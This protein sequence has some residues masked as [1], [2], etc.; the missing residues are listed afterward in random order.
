MPGISGSDSYHAN[1]NF[2]SASD[3]EPSSDAQPPAQPKPKPKPLR[4]TPLREMEP[5]DRAKYLGDVAEEY[6]NVHSPV[7]PDSSV[8]EQYASVDTLPKPEFGEDRASFGKSVEVPCDKNKKDED[9]RV[10]AYQT[11]RKHMVESGPKARKVLANMETRPDAETRPDVKVQVY[12][13]TGKNRIP[14]LGGGEPLTP[15]TETAFSEDKL[16]LKFD[17]HSAVFNQNGERQSAATS[18]GHEAKHTTQFI[19]RIKGINGNLS[20]G[21]GFF[22]PGERKMQDP[23]TSNAEHEDFTGVEAEMAEAHEDQGEAP[24]DAHR[25]V[26]TYRTSGMTS[27]TPEN[28]ET[29]KVL[30]KFQPQLRDLTKQMDQQG[31]L[32]HEY[33]GQNISQPALWRR[34]KAFEAEA[35]LKKAEASSNVSP[36]NA[37]ISVNQLVS[38]QA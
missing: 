13:F 36:N 25:A 30:E 4:L 3:Q 26:G 27:T 12:P 35:A 17:T 34:N 22:M 38:D 31:A 19:P 6:R 1:I 8:M 29:Q 11:L 14:R 21:E 5:Q 2:A 23:Y 7:T 18:A 15:E 32:P 37:R 9:E 20:S 10:K 24:R 16:F 28:P 33:T